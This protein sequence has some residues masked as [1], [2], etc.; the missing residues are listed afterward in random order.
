MPKIAD[1]GFTNWAPDRLPDL[2]GKIYLITGGNSGIGFDAARMLGAAGGDVV[3]ACRNPAKAETA[4]AELEKTAK[5]KIETVALDLSDLSSVRKAA[6]EVRG[7]YDK[8]DAL[9]NNAGIMQTPETRTVDGFELQLGTNHLGHFL[10]AGLLF[11][12]VEKAAG[13]IVVV[14]SIAHKF[15]TI[16]RDDLMLEKSYSPT[17]AYGQSKL[18]N[19]MFGLELDRR[20]KAKHSSVK[21]IVC[22]PGYSNTALQDTGPAGLLNFAYKFLNPLMAQPAEKGAI[23]TALAAAGSEAVS[24]AY[25]GPTGWGDTRG[26]VGDA[27]VARR[28]L[29][30]EMAHWLWEESEKLVDFEWAMLD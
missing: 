20:L 28:A 14:S 27:F 25:Y 24:G 30:E 21:A 2:S 3:I 6:D 18:A 22:H 1:S 15:G 4:V 11:D 13:R 23:P 17:N 19:I 16:Y 5:G 7:R 26:P 9:I 12:L 8:L 29:D 10:F